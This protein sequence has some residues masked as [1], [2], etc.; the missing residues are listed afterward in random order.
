[1]RILGF[2]LAKYLLTVKKIEATVIGVTTNQLAHVR[3]GNVVP[4]DQKLT[5][6]VTLLI[7]A[8]NTSLYLDGT[9]V[10]LAMFS[11]HLRNAVCE[12]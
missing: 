11:R 12:M 10:L 1:M 7:A 4:K 5:P 2:K 6:T 3:I 8:K 9:P